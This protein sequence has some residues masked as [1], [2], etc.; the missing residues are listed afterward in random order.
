MPRESTITFEQVVAAAEAIKAEGGKANARAVRERLGTGSMG[1]IH[2]QLQQWQAGQ[3]RQAEPALS[4]PP[5]VQRAVLDFMAQEL[6]AGRATL[7]ADLAEQQQAATDLATENERQALAIEAHESTIVDLQAQVAAQG[8]KLAQVEAD[9]T[10][11]R[12]EAIRERQ[13]AELARTELA[14]AHLRLEAMP[15]LEADLVA[16]REALEVERTARTDAEKQAAVAIEKACGI[17]ARL[18]DL[19]V[20]A[21]RETKARTEAEKQAASTARE[22]ADA[23]VAVQ[24]AQV[25]IEAAAREIADLKK[26][27][28]D[29]RAAAKIA[30]EEAAELRGRLGVALEHE[31]K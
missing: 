22:L 11:A 23:R 27:L 1:T 18:G 9:L 13:G 25:P 17:E 29:A 24:A 7:A 10:R 8:G 19:Q 15:R 14:K 21:E 16:A 26:A 6:A 20:K 3:G 5:A 12:D 28:A 31:A 2:R 30:G 4:L